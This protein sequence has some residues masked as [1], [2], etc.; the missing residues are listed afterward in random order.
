[1][2]G[3]HILNSRKAMLI[4]RY[5]NAYMNI[6]PSVAEHM[7]SVAKIAQGLALWEIKKFGNQVNMG[8]LLAKAINHD[9]IEIETGDI[10]STTKGLIPEMRPILARAEECAYDN[11]LVCDLPSSW[12]TEFRDYILRPKD[13][14]IEGR[15]LAA[16]DVI[17]TIY[18]A[19]EEIRLGN[20]NK[21]VE[22]LKH[23]AENL[24][25]SDLDS[26]KYFLKYSL[27]DLGLDVLDY[28]G[29][30]IYQH[31]KRL[32]DFSDKF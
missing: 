14:T 25:E 1:M 10:L 19:A 32:P 4:G 20:R 16:A 31:I 24:I 5:Q 22:V 28:F 11:I 23:S 18:E 21:F 3:K 12:R 7:W 13:S 15:I 17:D 29:I 30:D 2:F 9:L 26:V 27:Q 8:L 6:R